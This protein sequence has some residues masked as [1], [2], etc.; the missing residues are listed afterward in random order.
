M[1]STA[2]ERK[3]LSFRCFTKYV[4]VAFFRGGSLRPIPPG[5]SRSKDTRYLDIHED[6]R[7]DKAQ[8]AAWVKQASRL[9]GWG[10]V[11][12]GPDDRCQR[13]GVKRITGLFAQL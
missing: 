11:A 13:A 3:T 7:V 2:E 6:N 10:K 5:E 8:L 12:I 1:V 4:G 9:P